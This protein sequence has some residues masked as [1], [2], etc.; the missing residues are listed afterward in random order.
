VV[1]AYSSPTGFDQVLNGDERS[2]AVATADREYLYQAWYRRRPW[3]DVPDGLARLRRLSYQVVTLS[4]IGE[5]VPDGIAKAGGLAWD[6]MLSAAT[7]G[8]K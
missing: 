4:N 8:R 5:G 2:K 6:V 7:I 3:P 1:D